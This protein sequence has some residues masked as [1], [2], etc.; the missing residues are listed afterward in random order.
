[1]GRAN[2]EL[3]VIVDMTW[4][5]YPMARELSCLLKKRFESIHKKQ[6]DQEAAQRKKSSGGISR[7]GKERGKKASQKKLL[8]LRQEAA[9]KK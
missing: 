4:S 7:V 9:G 6:C 8:L 5:H 2:Q 1:M 3:T